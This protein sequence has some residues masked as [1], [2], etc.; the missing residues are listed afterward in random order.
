MISTPKLDYEGNN[1]SKIRIVTTLPSATEIVA[2]LGLEE[3]L[4]G[5]THECDYPQSVTKKPVVMR[6]KFD[7]TT[8]NNKEIDDSVLS[9]LTNGS[10]LYEIDEQLLKSL[11]PDLIVTQELCEVCATP[12]R[13][14]SRV[15]GTLQPKPNVLSLTPHTIDDVLEDI[16][17]VGRA[18]G[19]IE[20]AESVVA[21]LQR[22]INKIRNKCESMQSKPRVI[23][24]EWIDPIYCSGH[25]MP[26]LVAY[27][28]GRE[29]LGKLGKP[30]TIVSWED[31][32]VADPDALLITVCGYNVKRTLGEIEA[33]TNRKGWRNLK[34]VREGN[35][36]VL[37]GNSYYSRSGPRLVDGLEIMAYILHHESF[38]DYKIPAN[39]AYSLSAQKFL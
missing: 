35:I 34:A 29:L 19:R 20:K 15:I 23:C 1:S 3:N 31:V 25:W 37:D 17:R 24:L 21:D 9:T 32:V 5:I 30:S 36:Y 2:L 33:L 12:L 6:S 4:V 38:S 26:E 18:T 22:R 10:S 27:A 14:V 16:M 39:S 13:D 11:K 8:M 7:T 28:G